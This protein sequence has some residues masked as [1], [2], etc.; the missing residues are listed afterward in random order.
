MA[1]ETGE[2]ATVEVTDRRHPL[3]GKTWR[4]VSVSRRPTA[5]GHVFVEGPGDLVLRIPLVST[6]LGP[7]TSEPSTKI[8]LEAVENL[9]TCLQEFDNSC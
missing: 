7:A 1:D 6:N 9:L 5:V 4:V 2:N 3:F 8:T